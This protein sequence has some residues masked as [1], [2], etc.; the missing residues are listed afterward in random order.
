MIKGALG[1]RCHQLAGRILGK[2]ALRNLDDLVLCGLQLASCATRGS[3]EL[4][5]ADELP[6]ARF[7]RIRSEI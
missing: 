6:C 4:N 2:D 7:S 5:E 1:W 3:S